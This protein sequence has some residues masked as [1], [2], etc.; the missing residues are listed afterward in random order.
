M[1]GIF[2][3]ITRL[4]SSSYGGQARSGARRAQSSPRA[5]V[6]RSGGR[7]EEQ[8]KQRG[9]EGPVPPREERG[10]RTSEERVRIKK[11]STHG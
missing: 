4:R 7:S 5:A 1:S 6:S 2:H 10:E 3:C 11:G 9:P 8:C